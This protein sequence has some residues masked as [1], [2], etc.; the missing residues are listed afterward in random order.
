[1][2][3]APAIRGTIDP[4]EDIVVAIEPVRKTD[5]LRYLISRTVMVLAGVWIAALASNHALIPVAGVAGTGAWL[6]YELRARV[7][8]QLT[9][10]ALYSLRPLLQH[11][12]LNRKQLTAHA[13]SGWWTGFPHKVKVF[14]A[15][16]V[17][18]RDPM[19]I[20]ELID[21]L[22]DSF[23]GANYVRTKSHPSR[24]WDKFAHRT[25][26]PDPEPPTPEVSRA[27][28]VINKALRSEGIPIK[29]ISDDDGN[30]VG[31]D[32]VLTPEIST[33]LAD[34]AVAKWRLEGKLSRALHGGRW[35]AEIDTKTDRLIVTQ[36]PELPTGVQ[37][38]PL[39]LSEPHKFQLGLAGTGE[40]I[41]WDLKRS[42]HMLVAGPTGF[43]KTQVM[44]SV[45]LQIAARGWRCWICD[46]K[47]T[48]F[49]G[50]ANWPN[51]E[52]VATSLEEQ[53]AVF[54]A[55]RAEMQRRNEL[56]RTRQATKGSFEPLFVFV[57]EFWELGDDLAEWYDDIR[58]DGMPP[59]T[60]CPVPKQIQS[61][62]RKGRTAGVHLILGTQSTAA[63]IMTT[64]LRDQFTCRVSVGPLGRE[65]A[66]Q[67]WRNAHVGTNLPLIPG[68]A[69]MVDEKGRH[70]EA[71]AFWAPDPEQLGSSAHFSAEDDHALLNQLRPAH[72][73]HRPLRVVIPD[74]DEL[75]PPTRGRNGKP[76]SDEWHRLMYATL[77]PA[78]IALGPAQPSIP[79]ELATPAPAG[80]APLSLVTSTPRGEPMT[81]AE[82]DSPVGNLD[83]LE[84]DSPGGS[85]DD[86]YADPEPV[87]PDTVEAGHL[88]LVEE[89]GADG[90]WATVEYDAE[91]DLFDEDIISI[92]YRAT[93]GSEGVI[94]RDPD[95]E[96][97]IRR[98][99][100]D[101]AA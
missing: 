59:A 8:R 48:E 7:R 83:D 17:D 37:L 96:I 93:D 13:W 15:P 84:P 81:T 45:A 5:S 43:G 58:S 2:P 100:T 70:V 24:R 76:V 22:N 3:T 60:K 31:F 25:P 47:W 99:H 11:P 10:A 39:D 95:Q 64:R 79:G 36:R 78:P 40:A 92:A 91:P 101:T 97:Q 16:T 72:T 86:L 51:V 57:D 28:R 38:P 46:P 20:P 52:I 18:V 32:C 68:R 21:K 42:P 90:V 23:P 82:P 65:L 14:R 30:T 27:Q 62:V 73:Q 1:M 9:D 61:V 26:E 66:V 75:P 33:S 4:T 63:E 34:S 41:V 44:I 29:P 67:M 69:I 55:A 35:E 94:E 19:F 6:L 74:L 53:V 80:R 77:E 85:L 98:R 71:Q 56:I 50:L 87:S 89:D 88:V 54:Y 49:P 12:R